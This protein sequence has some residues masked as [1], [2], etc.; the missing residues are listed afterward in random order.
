MHRRQDLGAST[1]H[2]LPVSAKI[3]ILS[4]SYSD[5]VREAISSEQTRSEDTGLVW[6]FCLYDADILIHEL[7]RKLPDAG[8]DCLEEVDTVATQ[9]P[10]END[11]FWVEEIYKVG[12][13]L[14]KFH[15]HFLDYV[16]TQRVFPVNRRDDVGGREFIAV[17]YPAS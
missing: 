4:D 17:R 5:F 13:L 14:A 2:R 10:T 16:Y 7:Q 3:A 6:V 8:L 15:P 9:Y 12:D 1:A 11:C